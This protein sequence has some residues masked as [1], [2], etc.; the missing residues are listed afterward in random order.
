MEY[1]LHAPH[2]PHLSPR[3]VAPLVAFVIGGG[4]AV[5]I[6][7][8]SGGLD[9]SESSSSPALIIHSSQGD[10][11]ASPQSFGETP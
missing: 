6:V 8:V 4:V 9:S 1:A 3:V 10:Q 11:V 7:A 5:G 2:V